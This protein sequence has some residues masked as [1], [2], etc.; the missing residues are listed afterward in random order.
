MLKG[1]KEFVLR[2]NVPSCEGEDVHENAVPHESHTADGGRPMSP[3]P[4]RADRLFARQHIAAEFP[5]LQ[6]MPFLFPP[7]ISKHA[8]FHPVHCMIILSFRVHSVQAVLTRRKAFSLRFLSRV[9]N[10]QLVSSGRIDSLWGILTIAYLLICIFAHLNLLLSASERA[11]S[12]PPF[13][14]HAPPVLRI[15]Q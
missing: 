7:L 6:N 8:V 1:F 2:G 10:L 11:F 13:R 5:L 3:I 9:V 12:Q 15:P 4:D 14:D